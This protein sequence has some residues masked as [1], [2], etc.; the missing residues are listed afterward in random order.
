MKDK[1]II[2]STG[3]VALLIKLTLQHK[4]D[5]KFGEEDNALGDFLNVLK[6]IKNKFGTLS[7]GNYEVLSIRIGGYAGKFYPKLKDTLFH[8]DLDKMPL[9]LSDSVVGM[10]ATF[11]LQV[12]R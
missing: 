6:H 10:I 9:L 4:K 3:E 12:G 7:E 1:D 8:E 11:R 2:Y 5:L